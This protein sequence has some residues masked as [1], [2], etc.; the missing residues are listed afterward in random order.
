MGV[1]GARLSQL[2]AATRLNMFTRRVRRRYRKC[3]VAFFAFV[4]FAP[5]SR[6]IIFESDSPSLQGVVSGPPIVDNESK[7]PSVCFS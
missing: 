5:S 2:S 3:L 7:I 1:K 6:N 4:Y